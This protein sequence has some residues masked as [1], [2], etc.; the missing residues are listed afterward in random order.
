M[1]RA[2]L[3]GKEPDRVLPYEYVKEAPYDAGVIGS[4]PLSQ[5]LRLSD[6]RFLQALSQ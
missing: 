5:A 3:I 4:L 6:E 1:I 2:L